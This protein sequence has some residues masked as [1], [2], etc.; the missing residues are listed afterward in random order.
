MDQ[1]RFGQHLG[2]QLA[3]LAEGLG[4]RAADEDDELVTAQ[5]RDDVLL[6][7]TAPSRCAAVSRTSSP[8]SCP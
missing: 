1:V 6:L 2:D 3:Q 8:A 7:A 4:G 5:P